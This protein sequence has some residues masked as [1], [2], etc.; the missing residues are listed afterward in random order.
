MDSES[1][2]SE[3]ANLPLRATLRATRAGS[4]VVVVASVAV[5]VGSAVVVSSVVISVVE[6]SRSSV[7]TLPSI[8]VLSKSVDEVVVDDSATVVV[9]NGS[10]VVS[11]VEVTGS[12]GSSEVDTS[13]NV[14]VDSRS[15]L[16]GMPL[17]DVTTAELWAVADVPDVWLSQDL[18]GAIGIVGKTI[19]PPSDVLTLGG[20]SVLSGVS[21]SLISGSSVSGLSGKSVSV[22]GG[23]VNCALSE[24]DVPVVEVSRPSILPLMHRS[25]A[26]HVSDRR[27]DEVQENTDLHR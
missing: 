7:V 19:P 2:G 8:A 5:V 17:A 27:H 1:L 11:V 13:P 14:K 9:E 26:R 24:W 16:E 21:V 3:I 12:K 15:E 6:V 18:V 4:W 22:K 25:A 10:T 23:M 20:V